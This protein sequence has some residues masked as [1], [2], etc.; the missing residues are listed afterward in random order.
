MPSRVSNLK[1]DEVTVYF[2]DFGDFAMGIT[3]IYFI[4]KD[5]GVQPV[6]SNV[7]MEILTS[8]N[9][10][11]LNFAFPSQTLYIEHSGGK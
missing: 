2:S 4:E 7:N 8:F 11:G 6:T 9:Q 5:A 3:F 1:K 10:A